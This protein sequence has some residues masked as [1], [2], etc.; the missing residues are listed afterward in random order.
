VNT[1]DPVAFVFA[2]MM[3][4][5]PFLAAL[6]VSEIERRPYR[7]FASRKRQK[8]PFLVLLCGMG[9]AAAREAL[10]YLLARHRIA[11]VINC[12]V[13]GSLSRATNVGEVFQ[14]SSVTAVGDPEQESLP[15]RGDGTVRLCSPLLGYLSEARLL[16]QAVPLFDQAR[17]AELAEAGDLIDMEGS[18][19]AD[20]CS[21]HGLPCVMFKVVSDHA[22]DRETLLRNLAH[23]SRR[24]ARFITYHLEFLLTQDYVYEA[25]RSHV[26]Q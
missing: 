22:D 26:A 17:R 5:E 7:I 3:E 23:T 16:S 21:R 4:A 10:N 14:V 20:V 12:G 24:L 19:I 2:T 25:E 9:P 8:S 6:P 18:A 13:A 15:E 1:P 11:C